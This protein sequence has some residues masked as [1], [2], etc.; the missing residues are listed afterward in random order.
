M[1]SII[2]ALQNWTYYVAYQK[3][4]HVGLLSGG[5]TYKREREVQYYFSRLFYIPFSKL[6]DS[7]VSA[8]DF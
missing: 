6:Y 7:L 5:V 2:H 3:V 4:V 1:D 8:E